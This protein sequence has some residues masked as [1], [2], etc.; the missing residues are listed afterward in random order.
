MLRVQPLGSGGAMRLTLISRPLLCQPPPNCQKLQSLTVLRDVQERDVPPRSCQ[1]SQ[2]RLG[3]CAELTSSS[4]RVR[5]RCFAPRRHSTPARLDCHSS[6]PPEPERDCGA[7]EFPC[8]QK[9]GCVSRSNVP[10]FQLFHL[11]HCAPLPFSP[12]DR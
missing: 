6:A 3:A 12:G 1:S 11:I 7:F 5:R 10:I 4:R 2:T 9:D 8:H